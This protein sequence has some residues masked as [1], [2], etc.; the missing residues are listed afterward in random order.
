MIPVRIYYRTAR[1]AERELHLADVEQRPRRARLVR[2]DLQVDHDVAVA[3]GL[4]PRVREAEAVLHAPDV[5][6]VVA[7]H[8]AQAAR[9]RGQ[10]R[11]HDPHPAHVQQ[12]PH[13]PAIHRHDL[14]DRP[15]NR[16]DPLHWRRKQPVLAAAHAMS[17]TETTHT[18]CG[19]RSGGFYLGRVVRVWDRLD[20]G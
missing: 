16:L 3:G 15:L 19:G 13:V 20:L 9:E 7:G 10:V 17:E 14:V 2:H 6:V 8:E 4:L 12:P 11:K 18:K 5:H 1:R